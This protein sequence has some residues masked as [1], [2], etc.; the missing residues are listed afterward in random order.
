MASLIARL[1]QPD[2]MRTAFLFAHAEWG[3]GRTAEEHVAHCFA[4]PKY[5]RGT[6]YVLTRDAL[7]VSTL[8][9][10]WGAFGLPAQVVGIG[11]VAT[12][13]GERGKGYALRLVDAVVKELEEADSF[14][15]YSDVPPQ[16]YEKAGFHVLSREYQ[17][18]DRSIAM[19]RAGQKS[20]SEVIT[21]GFRAP[22]YF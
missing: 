1:A 5:A 19:M 15:L 17:R 12:A 9:A 21:Q 18:Y 4:S 14:F 20:V 22:D 6:W 7:P 11:S 3:E 13:P 16:L 10:Y 8:I 2:D